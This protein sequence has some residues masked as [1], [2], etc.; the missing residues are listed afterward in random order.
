M[1][2]GAILITTYAHGLPSHSEDEERSSSIGPAWGLLLHGPTLG[3]K[4]LGASR[5]EFIVWAPKPRQVDIHIVAPEDKIVTMER[6]AHGYWSAVADGVEPGALYFYRLERE[7]DRPDPASRFQP[8]GVHGPS[9]VTDTGFRWGDQAWRGV[10]IEDYIIYE[11]H[12]GT[13]TAEGTF[14]AAARELDGLVDLGITAVEIMPVAQFPGSRNWGYDGVSPFAVQNSYGGPAGLRRFVRACHERGLAAI[15]DVVYN[16][17]G[18]EG[19][20]LREFGGY[21]NSE[22]HTPWG[23][24]INF[25]GPGSD[26]VRR[27]FIENALYWIHEFHIDGLRLDAV[28]A[29]YDRSA[30]PFL[31]QLAA[32]VRAAS[33]KFGRRIYAIPENDLNDAR[34][35]TPPELGGD[36]FDAQW[37]DDFHHALHVLLTGE[38]D[39]YYQDFGEIWHLVKAFRDGFVYTGQYS[40]GRGR[41]HGSDSRRIPG[42][43]LVVF[44]QNHDQIGNR[45]LGE[46]LKALA[47]FESAKLAAG[48]TI[49]SPFLP[50]LFMGEEYGEDAPFLYFVS[51]S[52]A[53]LIDAVRTGRREEFADFRW[54]AEPPDPQSEETFLQSKLRRPQQD[55]PQSLLRQ[56]YKELIHLRRSHPALLLLS[57]DHLDA[58]GFEKQHVLFVRRWNGPARVV[59]AFHFGGRDTTLPLPI[60][61]GRWKKLI[62]SGDRRW[63]G[64]TDLPDAL[65]SDGEII[66]TLG[67]RSFAAYSADDDTSLHS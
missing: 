35:V 44:S 3:A 50:L 4:Y 41:S 56:F 40:K 52:E 43:R 15:L 66:L 64:N 13:F 8:E 55:G 63:G 22:Y 53:A 58:I 29:I 62:H 61:N 26:E 39:G 10:A 16:H 20:Y 67:P 5:T 1:G 49:L 37:S 48:A 45:M 6:N 46:R 19:N 27:F 12:I 60:R 31:R 2:R 21:F 7:R 57:K 47:G 34:L 9:A 38:N 25:D 24:A 28:H 65:D 36:G 23:E 59:M 14:D 30:N 18:P 42:A 33:H 54:S 17:F 51:H 11:L 32:A